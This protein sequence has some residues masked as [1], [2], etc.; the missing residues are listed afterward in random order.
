MHGVNVGWAM[1]HPKM[2]HLFVAGEIKILGN[3]LVVHFDY[4]KTH[5]FH[6]SFCDLVTFAKITGCEYY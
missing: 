1:C 5:I 6:M 2:A 4:C 3:L